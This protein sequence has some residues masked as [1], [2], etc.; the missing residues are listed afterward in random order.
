MSTTFQHP[1]YTAQ[2]ELESTTTSESQSLLSH[3]REKLGEKLT[4][5]EKLAW[6]G[7]I[8]DGEGTLYYDKTTKCW[9]AKVK[10]SDLDAV[11]N[12]A[13]LWDLKV[14]KATDPNKHPSTIARKKATG[15]TTVC[16]ELFY[17]K[18]GARDKL[19]TIVC[20]LYPYLCARVAE[21]SVM[22]SLFGTPTKPARGMT[23]A[24]TN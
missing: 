10:M 2:Q 5:F 18:T 22:S 15:S 13:A 9:Y 3:P 24:A 21:R 4:D 8:F 7:G 16:K 1:W 17:T 19:F 12:F 11:E 20:D 23:N 14:R 6:A